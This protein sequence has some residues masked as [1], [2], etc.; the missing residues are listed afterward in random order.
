LVQ[1]AYSDYLCGCAVVGL[2]SARENLPEARKH[3]LRAL[4]LDCSLP[5][6]QVILCYCAASL[7]HDWKEAGRRYDL[8]RESGS[9]SGWYYMVAGWGYLLAS[10]RRNE[11]VR[12]LEIAVQ[13]DPLNLTCRWVLT[14]C[15]AAVGRDAEAEAHLR[16]VIDL[17]QSFFWGWC[18]L[19]ELYVARG[20][21]AEALPLAEGAYS[22]APWYTPAVGIYGGLLV[23][24][25]S[26]DR[27]RELIETL[28]A[29]DTYGASTGLALYHLCLGEIEA[30]TDWFEKA[31]EERYCLTI[32]FL[33]GALGEPIR[34]SVRWARL[35]A[36]MNLASG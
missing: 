10:G 27:A 22:L 9:V 1:A 28:G 2:N 19:A 5:E 8:A 23:R 32:A 29:G 17:D 20:R 26:R 30:A 35:A 15:L 18:G 24:T 14:V 11:A 13:A 34:A 25:G 4:E 16:Q 36:M 7:D 31:I 6:A 3:A 33:Q 12:D 21:F